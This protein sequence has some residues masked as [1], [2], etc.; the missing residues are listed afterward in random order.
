MFSFQ[1]LQFTK[2]TVVLGIGNA[3]LIKYVITVVMPIQFGTQLHNALGS[4]RGV[5]HCG[6][7]SNEKSSLGCSWYFIG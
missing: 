4:S 2:Q 7:L 5:D 1:R 3:R 6:V